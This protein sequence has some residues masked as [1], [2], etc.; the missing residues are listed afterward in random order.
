MRQR[1]KG[2]S[3]QPPVQPALTVNL[4]DL[5]ICLRLLT[6]RPEH[7]RANDK[8]LLEQLLTVDTLS[9]LYDLVRRF[10]G[11]VCERQAAGLDDWLQRCASSEFETLK[12]FATCLKQDESAVR[13]ALE[14][15]WSNG[16]TEGQVNRL[17]FLKRQMYGRA[18]LDPLRLRVLYSP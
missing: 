18:Y 16:Q 11:L 13:M 10:S 3:G 6:A 1:R 7:L 12:S 14:L 17:K 9:K 4:P 8:L 15:P 5:T 2:T